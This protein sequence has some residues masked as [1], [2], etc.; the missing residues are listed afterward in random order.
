M[1]DIS[2]PYGATSAPKH[3]LIILLFK[4]HSLS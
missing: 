1:T 3:S 4:Y 2:P